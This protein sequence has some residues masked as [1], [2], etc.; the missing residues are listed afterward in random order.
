MFSSAAGFNKNRFGREILARKGSKHAEVC[1]AGGLQFHT[2]L[3]GV[4]LLYADCIQV[5]QGGDAIGYIVG[6]LL[7]G[8][9]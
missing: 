7:V 5:A 2:V 8:S 6:Y 1:T 9:S 3:P 4:Q